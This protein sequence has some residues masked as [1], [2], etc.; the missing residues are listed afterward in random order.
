MLL[1]L[2]L[3]QLLRKLAAPDQH[4]IFL[5]LRNIPSR[6][7][8]FVHHLCVA[9]VSHQLYGTVRLIEM[10]SFVEGRAAS[11]RVSVHGVDGDRS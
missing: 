4:S 5:P 6:L 10:A 1:C 8:V 11:L 3:G 9:V 2:S 7:I